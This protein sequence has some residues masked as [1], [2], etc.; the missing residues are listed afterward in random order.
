M[1]PKPDPFDSDPD[2]PARADVVIS[3]G[4]IIGVVAALELA[5]R[6]ISVLLCE[7]GLIGG[8]QSSRN[9]GWCRT[10]G[11]DPREI[12]LAVESLRLWGEMNARVGA[13]TGF[14][15]S[16]I[17]YL[18]NTQAEVA[19]YTA[20]LE[21]HARPQGLDS[22]LLTADEVA[23][24][25]PGA[26]R[27]WLAGL[28]TPSDGRAEPTKAAPA[29]AEAARRA[30]AAILTG[31]A[32]RGVEKEGGRISGVVT[33]RGRVACSTVLLAGGA[34]SRRFLFNMGVH[35]PQLGVVSSVQRTAPVDLGHERTLAGGQFAA[36]KRLDGGYT[37][38]HNHISVADIVPD[39]FR[40]MASF[41][42]VFRLDWQGIRLRLG[43]R[44][45]DEARLKRRWALDE[46]SPFET[47]RVLDPAPVQKY[48]EAASDELARA[49]PAFAG[50]PVVE[51]WAG[52]IDATPDTVPVISPIDA[53]P[54]LFVATGF[55]GHGFG[56]GP[57]GGRLAADLITGAT[58]LVDPAPF[59]HGRFLDGTRPRPVTGL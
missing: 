53:V 59:R 7:K 15:A 49:F 12:P 22:R 43:Q 6:G 42:P 50:V 11:R 35:L 56:V 52:L 33:E 31:T 39:S 24:L 34:W 18:L 3:G 16:G 30:G 51:R 57:A 44:F 37:I 29:I 27:Q 21:Q 20:W 23:E 38:A 55:S 5:E 26:R 10:M 32:V 2:L 48:L 41:L 40:L 17:L 46:V 36:R 19:S 47:V 28:Y 58:P 8:E 25:A 14:R 1:A 13:E 9:W 45:I 4:G 54:G